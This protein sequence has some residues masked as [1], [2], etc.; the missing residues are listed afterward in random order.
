MYCIKLIKIAHVLLML[1]VRDMIVLAASDDDPSNT[2]SEQHMSH[3]N[4]MLNTFVKALCQTA[5]RQVT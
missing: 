4:W 2:T 1:V 3:F 5:I